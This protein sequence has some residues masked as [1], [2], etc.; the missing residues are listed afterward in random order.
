M[1]KVLLRCWTHS[2]HE[3]VL[4]DFQKECI[5]SVSIVSRLLLS[6]VVSGKSDSMDLMSQEISFSVAK[7]RQWRNFSSF[8]C[9]WNSNT[10]AASWEEDYKINLAD[11]KMAAVFSGTANHMP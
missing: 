5:F 2:Q 10:Y 3:I 6:S 4:I 9:I 8:P 1:R 11:G 7:R